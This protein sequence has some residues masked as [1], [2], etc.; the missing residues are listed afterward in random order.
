[1]E[2]ACP[3]LAMPSVQREMTSVH[4]EVHLLGT[5]KGTVDAS[6]QP[7]AWRNRSAYIVSQRL[8]A[9]GHSR[10]AGMKASSWGG[11]EKQLHLETLLVS[12]GACTPSP[13]NRLP[14]AHW[15]NPGTAPHL[16]S[17][18]LPPLPLIWGSAQPSPT[19]QLMPESC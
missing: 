9:R 3:P 1:M 5:D 4:R 19:S 12:A 16:P 10:K 14:K 13:S 15:E 11:C 7:S 6:R 8:M 18:P 2:A 17:P